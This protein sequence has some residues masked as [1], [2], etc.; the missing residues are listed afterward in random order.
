M[1]VIAVSFHLNYRLDS[2]Y[3]WTQSLQHLLSSLSTLVLLF[4]YKEN[5]Q[6][7]FAS[8]RLYSKT[9]WASADDN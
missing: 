5:W 9:Y 4:F 3:V 6:N 8:D 2:D 7:A 1:Y